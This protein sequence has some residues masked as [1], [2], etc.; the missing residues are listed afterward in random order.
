MLFRSILIHHPLPA[1]PPRIPTWKDPGSSE[2]KTRPCSDHLCFKNVIKAF[3]SNVT[4]AV[5][6]NIC[7][8]M[9]LSLTVKT[10]SDIDQWNKIVE[11]L[12]SPP[13]IFLDRLQP[14][15]RNYVVNRPR[16]TGYSFD[17]LFPD[18]LFIQRHSQTEPTKLCSE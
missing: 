14:M 11:Q 5:S 10:P 17:N 3:K 8:G 7:D 12:G 6:F 1:P 18:E 16:H 4:A 2:G 13:P 9:L 15:V